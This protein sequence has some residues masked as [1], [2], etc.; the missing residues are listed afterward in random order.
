MHRCSFPFCASWLGTSSGFKSR[1][2]FCGNYKTHFGDSS[3]EYLFYNFAISEN[4]LIKLLYL[5]QRFI[6]IHMISIHTPFMHS[7]TFVG[8]RKYLLFDA[9]YQTSFDYRSIMY[10]ETKNFLTKLFQKRAKSLHFI[11]ESDILKKENRRAICLFKQSKMSYSYFFAR[12]KADISYK[13]RRC[14]LQ[15]GFQRIHH[16]F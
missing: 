8:S 10:I 2:V 7:Y 6:L 11:S 5:T 1:L 3:P 13:L 16:L 15:S 4:F 14:M 12:I 9:F